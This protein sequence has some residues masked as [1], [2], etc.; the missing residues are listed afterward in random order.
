VQNPISKAA[1]ALSTLLAVTT[2]AACTEEAT[3]TPTPA[4]TAMPSSASNGPSSAPTDTNGG[5]LSAPQVE[6]PLNADKFIANPCLSLDDSQVQS[7]KINGPGQVDKRIAP[8]CL[9]RAGGDS[10]VSISVTF[11]TVVK[12][13]LSNLYNQNAAGWYKNGYFEATEISGYP[14]VLNDSSDR[15]PAGSCTLAV[16]ITDQLFFNVLIQA[17]AGDDVCIAANNVAVATLKT[18]KENQ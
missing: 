6:H 15:R 14:A 11:M 17:R 3:G 2:L 5:S 4:T 9:W 7:F 13:G 8:G 16:G 12:N 10:S 18:I 1:I